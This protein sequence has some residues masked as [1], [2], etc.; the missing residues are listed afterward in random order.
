MTASL[1]H[2]LKMDRC[3]LHLQ[4]AK[5]KIG[6]LELASDLT[7]GDSSCVFASVFG[8]ARFSRILVYK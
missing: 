5:N 2:D 7:L 4:K 6:D 8:I 3:F 1:N